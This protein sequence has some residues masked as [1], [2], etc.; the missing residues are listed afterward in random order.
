M[1]PALTPP[2]SDA[3]V[4]LLQASMEIGHLAVS[5]LKRNVGG[6][7]TLSEV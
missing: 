4:R 7:Q 3:T 5:N 2:T 1:E 6:G